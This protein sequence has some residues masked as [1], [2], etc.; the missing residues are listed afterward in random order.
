VAWQQYQII[1]DMF[2]RLIPTNEP[3]LT[4]YLSGSFLVQVI[5]AP[6]LPMTKYI[7]NIDVTRSSTR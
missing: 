4:V 3:F 1:D 5:N 7:D 6:I 2:G